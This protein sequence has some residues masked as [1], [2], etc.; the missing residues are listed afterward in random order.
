M[1]INILIVI[2]ALLRKN[3]RGVLSMIIKG[4]VIRYYRISRASVCIYDCYSNCEYKLNESAA[5]EIEMFLN[6]FDYKPSTT[7]LKFLKEITDE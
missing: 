6:D 5:D 2:I 3:V 7:I 1:L 4:K